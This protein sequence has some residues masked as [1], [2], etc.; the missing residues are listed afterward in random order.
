MTPPKR[1][2]QPR[3]VRR[4]Y[5]KGGGVIGT[6]AG[7]GPLVLTERTDSVRVSMTNQPD[8]LDIPF[9]QIASDPID[10]GPSKRGIVYY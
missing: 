3:R 1:A 5:L 6:G 2:S 7:T 8:W 4:V 9:D 10:Q